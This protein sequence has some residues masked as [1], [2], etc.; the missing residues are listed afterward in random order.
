MKNK[1]PFYFDKGQK[2]HLVN[3]IIEFQNGM[4]GSVSIGGEAS[5]SFKIGHGVKQ[6]CVLAPT[7]FAF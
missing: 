5:D 7:L 1:C 6:G 2:V 4:T 3:L